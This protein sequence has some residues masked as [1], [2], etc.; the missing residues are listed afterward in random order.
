[1]ALD[2]QAQVLYIGI[3]LLQPIRH[4]RAEGISNGV[5][6]Q[7]DTPDKKLCQEKNKQIWLV[8]RIMKKVVDKGRGEWVKGQQ[9]VRNLKIKEKENDSS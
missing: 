6:G 5:H 7:E 1:M 2:H 3:S 8:K 9:V 4:R